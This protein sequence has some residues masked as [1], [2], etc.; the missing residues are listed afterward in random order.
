MREKIA[1]SSASSACAS[2]LRGPPVCVLCATASTQL[3]NPKLLEAAAYKSRAGLAAKS[4]SKIETMNLPSR[5]PDLNVLDYS[6]R[7]EISVRMRKQEAAGWEVGRCSVQ[8]GRERLQRAAD[9][10]SPVKYQWQTQMAVAYQWQ[11]SG[12]PSGKPSGK[13]RKS[14]YL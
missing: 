6:I 8:R 14:D 12:K 13:L 1:S 9:R 4:Q 11:S 2:S 3:E 5:S 7:R 10:P